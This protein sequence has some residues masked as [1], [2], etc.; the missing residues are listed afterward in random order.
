MWAVGVRE[1]LLVLVGLVGCGALRTPPPP[2]F[3]VPLVVEPGP[4]EQTDSGLQGVL[5]VHNQS[6]RTLTIER[7]EWSLMGEVQEEQTEGRVLAPEERFAVPLSLR[8]GPP[9]DSLLEARRADMA[10]TVYWKTGWRT[11]ATVFRQSVAVTGGAQDAPD[12]VHD[13]QDGG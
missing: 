9:E 5:H 8:P 12:G 13:A 2:T 6:G 4:V 7:V 1:S 10:G 11:D 3:P